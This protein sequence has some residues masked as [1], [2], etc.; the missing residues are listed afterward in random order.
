[1]NTSVKSYLHALFCALALV[2]CAL[3]T[4][5]FTTMSVCDDGP[6]IR[7]AQTLANTGHIVYNGWPGAMLVAQLYIS[8]PFIK[9]F[10]DSYTTVRMS[11]L[12][13]AVLL[14][15]VFHRTLVRIGASDRNAIL[16]TLALVLSPLYLLLSVTFMS[17]IPGFFAVT[18][19]LY[20]CV[21]SLQAAT[22]R[23]AIAWICFAVFGCALFGTCRQIAWLGNLVMVPS[24]LWLLR[25]RR[26]V[27]LAG[28]VATV[29]GF[30]FVLACTHW[31]SR[32]PYSIST[33]SLVRPFP[34]HLVVAEIFR[35]I[36]EIPFL[37]LPLIA[38][39]IPRIFRRP[40]YL[41]W[42]CLAALVT[43]V[44]IATL[45]RNSHHKLFA[46]E[47]TVDVGSIVTAYAAY[48]VVPGYTPFL[49]TNALI[50]LTIV[51]IGGLLG[52]VAVLLQ[53]PGGR[54]SPG[55]AQSL[56]WKQL[57]VLLLPFSVV[58]L[59]FLAAA[60]GTYRVLFDRYAMCLLAPAIIVLV[61]LYQDRVQSNLPFA[62]VLLIIFMAAW[63]IIL[64]H[65]TFALDRARVDLADEL[66]A[67]G[68][69]FTAIDGNWDYNIGTE[70]Q[71]S[72][73]INI[74]YLNAGAFRSP[75]PTPEGYCAS[76]WSERTP[77]V[78]GLYGISFDPRECYGKAPFAPVQYRPWPFR[79]PMN[80]Y[81]VRYAPP[82]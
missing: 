5:P 19:C 23:S 78:H 7:M 50:L 49:N 35:T 70:L 26:R 52:V 9:L 72:D 27:L 17:D 71:N 58:Y 76:Y 30:L 62:T 66:H 44:G 2:V 59:L 21:R 33:P 15:F 22:D 40:R 4:S 37:V 53:K 32:Q 65:N 13:I 64:T 34:A 80:L 81:A 8:Q 46:L 29:I 74:Q 61:R 68:I 60:A 16:A 41:T 57:G 77:H 56:S 6:Y 79:T 43:Y 3:I 67:N 75:P 24:T 12:L 63:A 39:F 14:A 48:T 42:T 82:R 38:V 47:P 45:R 1:M 51:C 20:G 18:L 25:S 28:A 54:P 36:L 10:G 73:H 31:Y 69:Q 55:S 11:T